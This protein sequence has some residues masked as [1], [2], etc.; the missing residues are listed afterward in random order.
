MRGSAPRSDSRDGGE[1]TAVRSVLRVGQRF[2]RDWRCIPPRALRRW[3]VTLAC[4][5]AVN[6]LLMVGM[7]WALRVLERAGGLRWEERWLRS[8]VAEGPVSFG[9]ALVLQ[10]MGGPVLLSVLVAAGVMGAIWARRPLRA[11][12][13][14][15]AFFLLA[16]V[17]LLGWDLGERA[18]P[19]LVAGGLASPGGLHAFPSGHVAQATVVYGLLFALWIRAS[20]SFAERALALLLLCAVIG[21]VGL[22]RL[23]IGVHWPTDVLAGMVLGAVWLAFVVW[24]LARAGDPE[25]RCD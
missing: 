1:W 4:G 5:L 16:P 3:S 22:G 14:P 23:R 10:E 9:Y 20:R 15:V 18:R 11:V 6:T 25:G 8:V 13:F 2:R 7:L 24:A 19:T 21:A 17:V 12:S